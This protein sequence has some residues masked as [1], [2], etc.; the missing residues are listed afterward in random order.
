MLYTILLKII[1]ILISFSFLLM[2]NK[3]IMK[4]KNTNNKLIKYIN[5]CEKGILI[6]K[7]KTI[8]HNFKITSIIPIYNSEKTIKTAIRSIQNQ[9]MKEIE[10]ILIDD[11]ST[12]NS[13]KVI[14]ELQRKD[15]RIKIFKNKKNRG[16]LYSK[17]VG[18]LNS[19]GEYI[20]LLDSDDLFAHIDL[21]NICFNE[22][23][24][25]NI[26]ILEFSGFISYNR[27]KKSQQLTKI[28][29][30]FR[31]KKNN[32]LIKQPY[33][34]K[35]IYKKKNNKIIRL[36]DGY[37]CGKCIKSVIYKK[38]LKIIGVNVYSK[39]VN[40]GDDRIVNYI[41]FKI[42]LRFKFI[43]V[44][45][46]IY[47]V[48]NKLSITHKKNY[49][50]NCHDELIN[51]MNL[52]KFTKN[53]SEIEIVVYEIKFRWKRIIYPGLNKENKNNLDNLLKNLIKS[54][55]VYNYNKIILNSFL[56]STIKIN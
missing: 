51:L 26:D 22:V 56:N 5:L 8:F 40:Y 43:D 17:S 48:Y 35:F 32:K 50:K 55:Y 38:S 44:K 27:D 36:V 53:T 47:N 24:L 31:F 4:R 25:N 11:Y 28:P 30:Y 9:K 52:Y 37:L 14:E 49:I 3:L 20:M 6:N 15:K 21:F 2:N 34:S 41:L 23:K 7:V 46:Y 18:A 1:L 39:N 19:K 42:A 54:K 45:G 33:L 10:I 12:D 13:L 16:A 29:I